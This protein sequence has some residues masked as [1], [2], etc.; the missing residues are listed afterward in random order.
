M[1]K[2]L[3]FKSWL[4]MLCML[5]GVGNAW[6]DKITDYT[7]IVSG[8]AYYIGAT[9]GGTDYYLGLASTSTGTGISGQKKTSKDDATLFIFEGSDNTWT[10]Q[11]SGTENYMALANKKNNGKVDV[12]DEA[13]TWTLSADGSLIEMKNNNYLLRANS[14]TSLNFGSYASGQI[15]VWLEAAASA[16]QSQSPSISGDVSFLI[17]T[18]VT[19]TAAEG[20]TIYYTLDGNDPTTSSTQYTG[21]F[22]L[23]ETT[24]VKAIAVESGKEPSD[25]SSKLFTKQAVKANIAALIADNETGFVQLTDALVTYV[26]NG[27]GYIQDASAGMYLYGCAGDLAAGDQI[28][29][30]MNVTGYTVYNNLPEVT[31]FTLVDGYTKTSGN[32]VTAEEVT[33]E[34]LIADYDNYLSRYVVIKGATVQSAFSSKNSTIEQNGN[35]IV[36]RDQNSSATLISTV[37]DVVDVY[38][39]PAIYNDTKQLSVWEQSQIVVNTVQLLDNVITVTG[40]GVEGTEYSMDP[41][42]NNELTLEATATSGGLVTFTLDTETTLTVDDDFIFDADNGYL[43]VYNTYAGTIVIKANCAANDEYK[44]AP[45]VTITINVSGQKAEP[46]LTPINNLGS[47][48]LTYGESYTFVNGTDYTTDGTLILGVDNT[49]VIQIDGNTV[50]AVAVGPALL[51]VSTTEG[52]T[53]KASGDALN[54]SVIVNPTPGKTTAPSAATTLFEETFDKSDG[55]GGRDGTFTGSVGTSSLSEK[56]D[57]NWPGIENFGANKCIKLGTGSSYRSVTTSTIALTGNGTLTFEAAG[58]GTGTNMLNVTAEGG[59]LSGDTEVTLTNGEFTSYTVNIADA[60]GELVLTFSMKRGFLD[61]IVVASAGGSS[62]TESVTLNAY[63]YGT[64][65]SVNPLDFSG[66][67]DFTAWE[68]TN[69]DKGVVTFNQVTSTI[70]G[71]QGVLLKGEAGAVVEI[72]MADG[73]TE[74]TDNLFVGIVNPTYVSHHAY[75]G[76]K[77]TSLTVLNDGVVPAGKAIIETGNVDLPEGVK[78]FTFVFNSTDGIQTIEKVSAEEAAKIFDLSGRRLAEMRRG[79]NI[80]NGKKIMVK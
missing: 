17:S 5:L 34:D 37:D 9:V 27:K 7:E 20:A 3:H 21:A 22:T 1:S 24:T 77:G 75:F 73:D 11:I 78:N 6:A 26:N 70:K 2:K 51:S 79:V 19:I 56:T 31:A 35:T 12:V 28:S 57:E 52:E 33:L 60:T 8:Q 25:V 67:N 38:C 10:I 74:L 30:I 50:T 59:T 18:T 65:A 32:T 53:Y 63:G 61:E 69:I 64:Y 47:L 29:G 43:L 36:M 13:S 41:D 72:P 16:D 40:N 42:N 23:T 49:D 45:E 39:H 80:V 54:L 14:S 44:A 46:D 76:L 48:E 66:E 55:T 4:L 62:A 58:W 15:A 71:G 68:V